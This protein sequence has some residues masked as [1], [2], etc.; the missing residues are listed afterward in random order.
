[1]VTTLISLYPK[2]DL[3]VP[4]PLRF[5]PI[6]H[7]FIIFIYLF[8]S[9]KGPIVGG[10]FPPNKPNPRSVTIDYFD[11]VCP[12]S[13]RK[14]ISIREMNQGLEGKPV[15]EILEKYTKALK[16]LN[17]SCVELFGGNDHVFDW[18]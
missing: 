5:T 12:E 14:K 18:P 9:Y 6:D 1:M 16:A 11:K 4:S 3:K 2:A 10:P 15:I 13:R 7:K 17:E 8:Y